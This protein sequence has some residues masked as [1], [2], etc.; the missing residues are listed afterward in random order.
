MSDFAYRVINGSRLEEDLKTYFGFNGNI[1]VDNS[2][3]IDIIFDYEGAT[4]HISYSPN[5]DFSLYTDRNNTMKIEEKQ[6]KKVPT[7][8]DGKGYR[9]FKKTSKIYKG[10]KKLFEERGLLSIIERQN[11]TIVLRILHHVIGGVS[12]FHLDGNF[13]VKSTKENSYDLLE[14]IPLHEFYEKRAEYE[15]READKNAS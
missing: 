6:L 5:K 1:L 14:S 7:Y 4:N 15:K 12:L 2:K 10:M 11:L 3:E 9:E 13:Y 8:H